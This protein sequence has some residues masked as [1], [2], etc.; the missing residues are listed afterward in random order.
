MRPHGAP[1]LYRDEVGGPAL[2]H[3]SL[4][5]IKSKNH[6]PTPY[7]Y[8]DGGRGRHRITHGGRVG[9]PNPSQ[10]PDP[11]AMHHAP[12]GP[13][14]H[15]AP[16]RRLPS[17]SPATQSRAII[18]GPPRPTVR[19]TPPATTICVPALTTT[20]GSLHAVGCPTTRCFHA[21]PPPRNRP[22]RHSSRMHIYR[23]RLLLANALAR[24]QREPD[25]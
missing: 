13:R 7:R 18:A 17:R 6:K 2:S 23:H 22:M 15:P 25:L 5:Q 12:R 8:P 9:E 3:S 20:H 1:I 19:P 4:Q 14:Y 11:T 21:P 24:I 16:R 10:I